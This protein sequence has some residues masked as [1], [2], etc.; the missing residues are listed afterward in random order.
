MSAGDSA[1]ASLISVP[2]GGGAISGLGEKFSP[3]LHTGTGNFAV[4][5]ALPG[6]R[7]G[8]KPELSLAY[9]TGSGN[10]P[11]GL[12]WSVSVPGIS[13]LTSKGIPQYR[14][15]AGD[16]PDT[17]V[18][19]GTEDLVPVESGVG[20]VRYR[21][22]TEGLFALITHHTSATDH[23]EVV[24]KD[25]LTSVYGTP[26]Q[27]PGAVPDA[28]AVVANPQNRSQVCTWRITETRDTF[29]NRIV[30]DYL[31]DNDQSQGHDAEQ[32][33]LK[34]I[35]YVDPPAG[36]D[37]PFFISVEFLYDQALGAADSAEP[38]G[39]A[40]EQ[41]QNIRPDPFSEYRSGFE[42]RTRRRCKW[43]VVRTHPTKDPNDDVLVRA[44]ELIYQDEMPAA[45]VAAP[46][47]GASLLARVNVI[48]Y[49]DDGVGVREMPPLDLGYSGFEPGGRRFVALKGKGLPLTSIANPDLELADLFGSG[50]PDIVELSG[51]EARYWRNLGEGRFD[52]PRTFEQAPGG[53]KLSDRGVQ[54]MDADGDG[55]LD[56]VV[57]TG[58][59]SGYYPLDFSGRFSPRSFQR[60]AQAPTFDLEDPEVR[61]LDLTG[62]GVT[63]VLRS[64]TSFECYFTDPSEGWTAKRTARV[65]RSSADSF[66]DVN[67]S[68]PR[69]KL[70]DLSGDGLQ[71]IA[72]V[73]R[74]RV[75]YWPNLGFGRFGKRL[76]MAIPGGLPD[77]FDPQ[78][79]ILGDVDGD[80]LSDLLYV[81]DREVWLWLNRTGNAWSER[82]VIHGTPAVEDMVAVRL[83]DLYGTGVAGLLWTRDA[84]APGLP[85][86][87]FLD[88]T[89]GDKPYL[90]TRIDNNLGAL[91]EVSYVSSTV[92]FVRDGAQAST[93]WRTTL[94]FPVQVVNH[95]TA[96]DLLSQGSLTTEYRYHHGYWDGKEREF[97][98]FGMVEQLDTRVFNAYPGRGA[99]GA[100]PDALSALL[101]QQ[102]FIPPVLTRTW[103]HQGPVDPADGGPWAEL[104]RSAEYW[105]GDVQ[106]A[107]KLRY[108]PDGAAAG[109]APLTHLEG[110][111]ALLRPLGRADQRDAL[112]ALCGNVL[113]SET[114]ALDGSD[115]QDRPYSVAEHA[116]T[117]AEVEPSTAG[118]AG[119]ARKRIYFPQAVAQRTTQWERGNEP[120]YQYAF[121]GD[122]DAFGQPRRQLSV[123]CPRSWRAWNDAPADRFLATL[124]LTV[125]ATPSPQGPKLRDRVIRARSYELCPAGAPAVALADLLRVV[126]T[127]ASPKH[128]FAEALTYYDGPAFQGLAYGE[129]GDHG[130]AVRR[131]ALVLTESILQQAY[132]QARPPYLTTGAAFGGGAPYPT[133]FVAGLPANAGYAYHAAG[134]ASPHSGGWYCQTGRSS[135]D[136]QQA[137]RPADACGLLLAQRDP[138]GHETRIAAADYRFRLLPTQV[139][140]A[141]GLVT[142][143]RYNLR[144]LQPSAVVDING[145]VT[146]VRFSP[147]GL[148]VATFVRG[149]PGSNEGDK[150]KP[151]VRLEYALRAFHDSRLNTPTAPPRPVY[152]RS[153]RR[154]FHDTDPDNTDANATDP[155]D[156]GETIETREYS[157]GFGRSLQTRTQGEAVRFGDARFGGGVLAQD[158]GQGPAA[159]L[160][161]LDNPDAARPNV[162]VSGWQVYDDK[163]RVVKKYE[164][165]FDKGWDYQPDQDGRLGQYVRMFYDALG[166]PVRTLNPDNSEQRVIHGVPVSLADPPLSPLDT[167]KYRPTPWEAYTYDA[168][169]NAGRTHAGVEPHTGYPHHYN[170][171][172]SAQVDAMGRTVRTVVRHRDPADAAGMLP[173]IEEHV[174]RT[175]YDIQGNV[176]GIRDALGRLAFEYTH[177]LAKHPLHTQ[178]LDAGPKWAVFDA[179]GNAL[180]VGDAKGALQLHGFDALNRPTRMWARDASAEPMTLRERLVYGD[181]P[182]QAAAAAVAT[183]ALGRLVQH[184]DEA[185]RVTIAA[186]DF[187]G[188]ALQTTRQVLSDDFLLKPYQDELARPEAERTWA[189]P[190]A[191]V[192]WDAAT[193]EATLGVAYLA[194]SAFDALNRV[195]WSDYPQA[196][197]GERFRLRPRYNRAGS[198]ESVTLVG[199][200]DASDQGAVQPHVQRISY[201]AKGQRS[202]IA[203]GNG[204]ATRYAYEPATFRLARMRTERYAI[205]PADTLTYQFSGSPLQDIAYAYDLTGNLLGMRDTTPG[206]GVANSADALLFTGDLRVQLSAGNALVRRFEYDPLYR[207][208]SATGRES[209]NIRSPR[210]WEDLPRK[211][212]NSGNH[213]TPD[214]DNAPKLTALYR[215]EYAYDPAG[216][217]LSLRHSQRVRGA[218]GGGRQAAW[219]RRFGVGG[220]APEDWRQQ[221]A[222]HLLGD[223]PNAPSNRLTHFE[224]S[225]SSNV[226][227]ASHAY[228]ASGNMVREHNER[229]FEWDRADRMKAF[230]NQIG[231]A[232]PTVYV[233]YLYDATGQRVKKLVVTDN[234]QAYRTTTCV[235]AAFEHHTQ[236]KMDGSEKAENCSIHVMDGTARVALQR[237]GPAFKD[238]GAKDHPVQ[239]Q[240][241]DHL[242]SSSLVV[243]SNGD[244][245]NREE[246]FPY[247][248]TSFGSFGKKRYRF[249]GV[250]RDEESGLNHHGV[251][252][253]ASW[254]LRWVSCDPAGRKDTANLYCY[255]RGRAMTLV[256]A[257][258]L[259]GDTPPLGL[260]DTVRYNVHLIDRASM[261]WNVQ[262]DHPLAQGKQRLINPD[263]PVRDNLTVLQET[264]K[265]INGAPAKPHTQAT[266]HDAQ[267][268]VAELGR[269]RLLSPSDWEG[270]SFNE[271]FVLPSLNARMRSGYNMDSTNK[272]M[273]DSLGALFEMDQPGR[274]ASG[275]SPELNWGVKAAPEHGA[276]VNSA[277]GEVVAIPRVM[278]PSSAGQV[279][280]APSN[281]GFVELNT[282]LSMAG[283]ALTAVALVQ[284]SVSFDQAYAESERTNSR[285]PLEDEAIRQSGRW[286]FGLAAGVAFSYAVE[287]TMLGSAGGPG[288]A[289]VGFFVGMAVGA[290]ASYFGGEV[291][292][293]V[294]KFR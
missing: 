88:F 174:T 264:G 218:S 183:N 256:D 146:E 141:T 180:E 139:T 270:L 107:A 287:G 10:G 46:S 173:P 103:F 40:P 69:V 279:G 237:V 100:T 16:A 60:H 184:D 44:Y 181:D 104:D 154:V 45:A 210:P 241:G 121:T 263:A 63:D 206:C 8:L 37:A 125:F 280:K 66:P 119:A 83:T 72:V 91:T 18:L 33:Y 79:V 203:Y 137:P 52:M 189:L 223:W 36:S 284:T 156:P 292:D 213:G 250:E 90:L 209:T 265:A 9:S 105:Q 117:L 228:D 248:E 73:Q 199:P 24:T 84:V 129:V 271:E 134:P 19:S 245:I 26:G 221:S 123:A 227:N 240:F 114:Y 133:D 236:K 220:L 70:A 217:I 50:L 3:D 282:S 102:S 92:S 122:Y 176:S 288:G 71:D 12:G 252:Y 153:I 148:P 155:D 291:A 219:S 41:P 275:K 205:D 260:N 197:N 168:N 39:I 110:M 109:T 158:Q 214:Q 204:I 233:V 101:G 259:E 198:L 67:F 171:P 43:I 182:A 222:G 127:D 74:G 48:G 281:G 131:E 96:R 27:L 246:F 169:D 115:L 95:V 1:I 13:R 163:G 232:R 165:F 113:R 202:L 59:M 172:T 277:T 273:L 261:G 29:G 11:F 157:D 243:S 23:W 47:N 244:W 112:R 77:G 106:G 130:V 178:S 185:G 238:D 55:R 135:F 193:A 294:V 179:A 64:G 61:L 31:R 254:L 216:N 290:A 164:P 15:A 192:D 207:L 152:V 97:R 7:N 2:K 255:V 34:R 151:S 190:P 54:L 194:R 160:G 162:I 118:S 99:P 234:G 93:R 58:P 253:Y 278:K 268:D 170:T 224:D 143:A 57:T 51:G 5:I 272:A 285:K 149:K 201:N 80:G 257:T 150:R 188:N 212:Y 186:Y 142:Q 75:D 147:H 262:K 25:G 258:G 269:L 211:G 191:R 208:T 166:R 4:S 235:G 215:E 68:N 89:G 78:R 6:G 49:G 231:T 53:L 82:V 14:D 136:F 276:P 161:G 286:G 111:A 167:A 17:F 196:A 21:P 38:P 87:F 62:D 293:A 159:S 120:M 128:L 266:F 140:G 132:G 28:R 20:V 94:P 175:T 225:S 65:Q 30:Y 145:N 229:H 144:T 247:G 98:G 86:H 138:L 22:R 116:Y 283:I 274:A 200:L 187:K 32:L 230:R 267:S 239:F 242:G 76:T 42:V 249:S 124:S 177:D 195:K 81:S 226:P 85:Q 251:R 126:E 289:A 56:L 35:R 108:L